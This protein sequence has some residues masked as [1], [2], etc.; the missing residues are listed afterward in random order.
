MPSN[1]ERTGVRDV[2]FPVTGGAQ[3]LRELVAEF[4]ANGPEFRLNVQASSAAPTPT[5]TEAGW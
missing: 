1:C 3:T 5:I 4:Q 2:V